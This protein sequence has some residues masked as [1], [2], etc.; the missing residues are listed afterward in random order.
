MNDDFFSFAVLITV[1]KKRNSSVANDNETSA[2]PVVCDFLIDTF[3]AEADAEVNLINIGLLPRSIETSVCEHVQEYVARLSAV[4]NPLISLL[5]AARSAC[6]IINY[7]KKL[8]ARFRRL[9][10]ACVAC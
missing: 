10:M 9:F 8:L 4:S 1:F 2:P 5:I 7:F 3:A 6:F